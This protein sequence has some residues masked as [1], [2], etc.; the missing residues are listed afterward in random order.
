MKLATNVQN[1]FQRIAF[2]VGIV[3]LLAMVVSTG[4]ASQADFADEAVIV[5]TVSWVLLGIALLMLAIHHR[6]DLFQMLTSRQARYGSNS[7]I[8]TLS[9]IGII[10]LVNQPKAPKVHDPFGPEWTIQEV[11]TPPK[12]NAP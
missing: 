4:L 7:L 8:L 2:I 10:I 3:A 5:R 11:S 12:K 1:P 9:F 6:A